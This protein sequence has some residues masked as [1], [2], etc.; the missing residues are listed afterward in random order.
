[1]FFPSEEQRERQKQHLGP[2]RLSRGEQLP[3]N[4]PDAGLVREAGLLFPKRGWRG[5]WKKSPLL[6]LL[7]SFQMRLTRGYHKAFR[8]PFWHGRANSS[9]SPGLN[10]GNGKKFLLNKFG[11]DDSE[12]FSP[13]AIAKEANDQHDFIPVNCR[14]CPWPNSDVVSSTAKAGSLCLMVFGKKAFVLARFSWT[15]LILPTMYEWIKTLCFFLIFEAETW[16]RLKK[17]GL[18]ESWNDVWCFLNCVHYA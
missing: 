4:P 17:T 10:D 2:P 5:G 18:S 14:R 16:K 8:L 9:S 3:S 11:G 6:R 1:M 15:K 12:E 13:S 7:G